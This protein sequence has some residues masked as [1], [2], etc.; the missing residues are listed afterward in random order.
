M[1]SKKIRSL[2]VLLLTLFWLGLSLFA[3]FH[4]AQDFSA[5][6]RR[7]LEQMPPVSAQNIVSGKFM[8]SFETYT[9]DQFP[10][11]DTFRQMKAL[12][13]YDVLRQG[14]NNGIYLAGGYAAKLEYP[15]NEASVR[16]AMGKF[17]DLHD[18]YLRDS[19]GHIFFAVVPDKSY[20]LARENGYPAMDYDA[21]FTSVREQT[22]WATPIDLTGSLSAEDYY[23]TDTHWRQEKILPAAQ[24]ICSAMEI[25]LLQEAD[26]TREAIEVP[27]Y[28]VYYG[29]AALPMASETLYVLRNEMLDGCTVT[30]LEKNETYRGVYDR[31]KLTSRDLYDVFLSGAVSVLTVENPAAETDR[32]LIVFRDSF[33]SSMIPLLLQGYRTVTILDTRYVAPNML[34]NLVDFHGQDV[35]FL[36]ST[37]V[38]NS[39]A[40]LK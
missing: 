10:L 26:Y 34:S 22:P 13:S 3:W 1:E 35:L 25:P 14:D 39:S 36:Y 20:Y 18:M 9:L 33:G 19:D 21:L 40:A 2:G 24:A 31:N 8:S 32:E 38:I 28:G 23:R 29:Q 30:N 17:N 37:L 12:F 27:F 5:S 4:P 16:K 6:E 11:R 15:L 7:K